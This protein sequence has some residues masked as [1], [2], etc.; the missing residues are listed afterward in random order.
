[1]KRVLTSCLLYTSLSVVCPESQNNRD[2][3][4][5]QSVEFISIKSSFIVLSEFMHRVSIR[6]IA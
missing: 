4:M 2:G 3:F 1:M 6:S 5:A